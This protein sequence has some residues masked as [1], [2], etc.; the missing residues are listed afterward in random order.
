MTPNT[1]AMEATVIDYLALSASDKTIVDNAF[2]LLNAVVEAEI[3]T[4]N[5]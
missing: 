1:V 4:N 5:L 2:A 3:P